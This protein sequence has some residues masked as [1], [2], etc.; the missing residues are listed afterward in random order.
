MSR[1]EMEVCSLIKFPDDVPMKLSYI[2][3]GHM[4]KVMTPDPQ[5]SIGNSISVKTMMG[6][7]TAGGSSGGN[8]VSYPYSCVSLHLLDYSELAMETHIC[9]QW[10]SG[11]GIST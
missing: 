8:N 2:C 11:L 3:N 7:V 9:R 6:H 4:Y 5:N 1:L 10:I